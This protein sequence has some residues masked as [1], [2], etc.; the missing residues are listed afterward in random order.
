M[1]V[2]GKGTFRGSRQWQKVTLFL[3]CDDRLGEVVR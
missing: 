3:H 1:T 2:L